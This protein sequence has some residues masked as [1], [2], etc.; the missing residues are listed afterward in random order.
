MFMADLYAPMT[1]VRIE[2]PDFYQGIFFIIKGLT[3]KCLKE[4]TPEGKFY[5]ADDYP[6]VKFPYSLRYSGVQT[7]VTVDCPYTWFFVLLNLAVA[8]RLMTCHEIYRI[9][10]TYQI[11]STTSLLPGLT[12]LVVVAYRHDHSESSSLSGQTL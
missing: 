1:G 10:S 9:H 2:S 12:G 4:V 3:D 8:H 5:F 6:M 11:N 7:A